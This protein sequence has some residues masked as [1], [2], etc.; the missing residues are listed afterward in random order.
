MN[1]KIYSMYIGIRTN[2]IHK[3]TMD[4]KRAEKNTYKNIVEY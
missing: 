2:G 3:K 4:K 1:K